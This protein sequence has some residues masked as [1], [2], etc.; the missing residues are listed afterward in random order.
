MKEAIGLAVCG[1]EVRLA[2]LVNYKGLVRIKALDS[3]ILKTPL[4]H[5]TQNENKKHPSEGDN[6]DVF[7]LKEEW[8]DKGSGSSKE[9]IQGAN[10]EILYKLLYK[11]VTKKTRIAINVPLSTVSYQWL[12][13]SGESSLNQTAQQAGFSEKEE[14]TNFG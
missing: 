5:W 12:D 7:G 8:N 11:H 13:G 10:L 2:H 6:P 9:G 1:M 3:A 4:D 14:Y